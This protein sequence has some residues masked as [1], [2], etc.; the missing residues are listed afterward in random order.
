MVLECI[1]WIMLG[2]EMV[3]MYSRAIV[4]L[5]NETFRNERLIFPVYKTTMQ[6]Q[7]TLGPS[8]F[9]LTAVTRIYATNALGAFAC[10]FFEPLQRAGPGMV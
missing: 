10:L 7:T 4:M 9:T 6:H 5:C 8:Q 1:S 3:R 2:A